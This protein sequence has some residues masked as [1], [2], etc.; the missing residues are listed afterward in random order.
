MIDSWPA[1]RLCARRPS[2]P[3]ARLVAM[4]VLQ[5]TKLADVLYD[6]RG[7]ALTRAKE[8]ESAGHRVLKLNIGNPAPFG[9]EAPHE[10]LEDMVANLPIAQGYSDSKGILSA[11]RAVMQYAQNKGFPSVDVED[12]YLGNG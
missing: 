5:S 8:L 3:S 12:I 4:E 6:V 7:P 10:L 9:F 1:G 2:P 11:R